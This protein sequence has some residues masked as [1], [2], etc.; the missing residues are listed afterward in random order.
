MILRG[1]ESPPDHLT[2]IE[3]PAYHRRVARVVVPAVSARRTLSSVRSS[4]SRATPST[5]PEMN[6]RS[7]DGAA[8]LRLTDSHSINTPPPACSKRQ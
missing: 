1:I 8:R 4:D 7:S 6:G 3:A 2:V 5:I